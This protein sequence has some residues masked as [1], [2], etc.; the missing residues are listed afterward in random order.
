MSQ[1]QTRQVSQSML[2]RL[3]IL[4]DFYQP[5]IEMEARARETSIV[6]GEILDGQETSQADNSREREASHPSISDSEDDTYDNPATGS[7]TSSDHVTDIPGPLFDAT[8]VPSGAPFFI[9]D[10]VVPRFI[11]LA[12]RVTFIRLIDI[13]N[14]VKIDLSRDS[15]DTCTRIT[16]Q[17]CATTKIL[18]NFDEDKRCDWCDKQL[19]EVSEMKYVPMDL[20]SVLEWALTSV[21]G[22]PTLHRQAL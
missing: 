1:G 12:K 19:C 7:S 13:L 2:Y 22:M 20:E 14:S 4:C 16:L 21:T 5:K 15:H 8:D 6:L 3:T 17:I 9:Q 10:E 18:H 11:A